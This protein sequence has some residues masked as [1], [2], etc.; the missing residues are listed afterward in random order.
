MSTVDGGLSVIIR[1][2]DEEH[3]IGH[4][5]QSVLDYH[6][7]AEILIIDDESRDDSMR[8]VR[9]FGSF[10]DVKVWKLENYSPGAAIN[11]GVKEATKKNVLVFSAHCQLTSVV[12]VHLLEEH[13]AIWG[14]QTP[15]YQGKKI[16]PRYIWSNFGDQE[17][18]NYIAPGE[19]RYFLHN[20]LALYK[21]DTL[22]KFP[23]P[24]NLVGKEDRY[25]ASNMIHDND[26]TI[27]YD[28]KLK[29]LHHWTEHRATWKDG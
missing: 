18:V 21:R 10:N 16:T 1:C 23:F 13:C 5:I 20:A 25:W 11:Q 3:W 8:I 9:M 4:A 12:E 26:L 2:R 7:D 29:C 6:P 15:I 28:P 19:K 17:V 14:K 24:E 22:L 27:G